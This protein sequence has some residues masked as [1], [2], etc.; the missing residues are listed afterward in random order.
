MIIRPRCYILAKGDFG[1]SVTA[2]T[3]LAFPKSTKNQNP[4]DA[5]TQDDIVIEKNVT[6]SV[7]KVKEPVDSEAESA[8]ETE[9]EEEN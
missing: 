1:I 7:E 2:D 6:E 8:S 5:F 4:L 9:S 3:I